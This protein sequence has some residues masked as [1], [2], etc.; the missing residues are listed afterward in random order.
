MFL[1]TLFGHTR[2]AFTGAEAERS[3]LVRKAS[4]GTLFMDEIGDLEP[5][6]QVKLLR[7]LDGYE[8]YTLGS[9][10]PC[11]ANTSM[12]FAT[13]VS[14]SDLQQKPSFRRDFLYRISAHHIHLPPLRERIEDLIPLVEY[15]LSQAPG[16]EK[17]AHP[18][19]EGSLID[20]MVLYEFPGNIRELRNIVFNLAQKNAH[21]KLNAGHFNDLHPILQDLRTADTAGTN[22]VQS[23]FQDI[24]QLPTIEESKEILIQE[25]LR[26]TEGNQTRAARMLG[27]SQQALN[28]RLKAKANS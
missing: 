25:A 2:G 20:A 8:F 22:S 15:F 21:E 24:R 14:L 3:G 4:M 6:A 17:N 19:Y 10:T 7:L 28:K 27:L 5:S 9:D 1:D 23:I 12:I 13:N 18:G 16:F 26:R 11:Y